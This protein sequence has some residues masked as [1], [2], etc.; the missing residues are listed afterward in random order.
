MVKFQYVSDLHLEHYSKYIEIPK[1]N[2]CENLFLLGDIGYPDNQVY[3]DFIEYCSKKWENVFVLFGNHEYH[4][5]CKTKTMDDINNETLLFPKNV[6]FLDNCYYFVNKLTN[7]VTKHIDSHST[8]Y[9]KIVG[10]ILWS[11]IKD[12]I[13]YRVNDY[14]FIYT[15]PNVRLTP[16]I[17][18]GMFKTN[19]E[20]ILK[21]LESDVMDTILL[22]HHGVHDLCNGDYRGNFMESGYT[23]NILE[24]SQFKH[25]LAC[26]SGH[27]HSSVN[28]FIPGTNIRLLSNCYGYK[29]ENQTVVKY[30]KNAFIDI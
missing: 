17:T 26:I 7:Q 10:S 28:T 20:Y 29:G 12:N 8:D 9:I 13:V 2:D 22:T 19:K 24:L 21:Q 23:T 27:T 15:A 18:R 25:L 4:S 5:K 16:D 30:N 14:R 3:K 11:N 6:Y 1:L